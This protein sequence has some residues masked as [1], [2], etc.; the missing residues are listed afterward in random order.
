MSPDPIAA[1]LKFKAKHGLTYPLVSDSDHSVCERYGVWA[2][3]SMYGKKY[4][5]VART[6]FVID[7]AGRIARLFEKVTPRGHA[8]DVAAAMEAMR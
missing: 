8:A 5:G 4:W 3:K 7:E 2:E 1:H 6:T